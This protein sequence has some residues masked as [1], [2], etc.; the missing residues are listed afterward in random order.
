MNIM[1]FVNALS[2]LREHPKHRVVKKAKFLAV[3]LVGK[4][5]KQFSDIRTPS[6]RKE[7][8]VK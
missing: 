4:H 7:F 5:K 2:A 3:N 6:E 8:F 1:I